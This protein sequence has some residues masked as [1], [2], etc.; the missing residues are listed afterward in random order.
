MKTHIEFNLW[1]L[2]SVEINYNLY[3]NLY[4]DY[5]STSEA[6]EY[7]S[8]EDSI[9]LLELA[10]LCPATDGACVYQAR[11]L[12]SY[13]YH[14]ILDYNDCRTESARSGKQT[15]AASDQKITDEIWTATIYPNPACH[16]VTIISSSQN[17]DIKVMII[18]LS[19]RTVLQ[20]SL[21][22]TDFASKL[23]FSLANGAYVLI[24]TNSH[25]EKIIRKLL[26]NR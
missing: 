20:A 25:N 11:A 14:T 7:Y 16:E 13:I 6:D 22:T 26:V 18:D 3:Y 19:G 24:A 10:N 12:Y 1:K 21:K 15:E 5:I 9:A 8:P 2:N 4:A 17:E 23:H